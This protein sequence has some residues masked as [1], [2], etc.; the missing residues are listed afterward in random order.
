MEISEAIVHSLD[1]DAGNLNV[2]IN[3]R[4]DLLQVD[5]KLNTLGQAVLKIYGQVA[6]NYGCFD[7][8]HE[9]YRF[10]V[11]LQSY[12]T[13][14]S[15]LIEFSSAATRLIAARMGVSPPATGGFV[16]FLRYSAQGRDW[17][18]I[19]MLKL[20]AGTGIDSDTLDLT[21]SL[22]FDIGHLHEAAR[23]DLQ[24]W[25]ADTQPYL[26]F[27]KRRRR[28]DVTVY[29][30]SA[31]GCTDYT[32]SRH[33]TKQA[34]EAVDAFAAANDWTPERK[35]D[36]RR[37][38]FNY[39]DEKASRSESV[40]LAALSALINDQEPAAFTEFVREQNYPINETFAPHR[41]TYMR[42][43]RISGHVG[44]VKVSFDVDDLLNDTI[45]YDLDSNSLVVRNLPANLRDD[46][47]KAQG[48]AAPAD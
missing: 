28:D 9:T 21:D 13:N 25:Q 23:I 7:A 46:I 32:D 12:F 6:N 45:A 17:L 20:K 40:H 44:S 14:Q 37:I 8:D 11:L 16:L 27:V 10:P 33:N 3:L 2:D 18:L 31:L 19:T 35:R 22:S 39:C 4:P 36:A 41:S 24:R 48:N 5:G 15:T 30:R 43:Q 1:K 29:F 47:L 38:T 26:S 42:F 34:L